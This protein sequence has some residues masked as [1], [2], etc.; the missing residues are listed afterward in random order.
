LLPSVDSIRG[1]AHAAGFATARRCLQF[2][3]LVLFANDMKLHTRHLQQ[4]NFLYFLFL[5]HTELT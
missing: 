5:G 3:V 4:L 2:L 1:F